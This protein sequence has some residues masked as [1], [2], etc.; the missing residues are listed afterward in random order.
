VLVVSSNLTVLCNFTR[1]QK[2]SADIA[3]Y[4]SET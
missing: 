1:H 2:S 4:N 3:C